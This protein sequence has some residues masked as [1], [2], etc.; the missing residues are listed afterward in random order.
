MNEKSSPGRRRTAVTAI[1]LLAVLTGLA[2]V[3]WYLWQGRWYET[4]NNAYLTGNL[5]E[6][7][8]QIGGTVVWIG[9]EQ[10]QPVRAGDEL[11]RLADGDE[12]QVLALRKQELAAAVQAVMMLR[13]QVERL[14]AE[15]RLQA[16]THEL[17]KE[18]FERRERL[19]ADNMVSEEE[20][21]TA[22]TRQQE[23]LLR[24][25]T[26]RLALA[27]A[28][29][30]AGSSELTEHPRI[31]AAAA[32]LGSSYR[33]WRK[34]RVIAPVSGEVARRRVQAGQRIQSG[35]PLFSIAQRQGAWVEANFKETQLRH[36]RPG[37]PVSI[38][39]DLYG[40]EVLFHGRVDSIGTG[41]GSVF[42]LL[43]PQNAT[44][45]WI[46]IVQRVP[47]RIELEEEYD[48]HH[49]LPFGAS[50]EVSVDTH[51]RSGPAI[52]TAAAT[53]P[54][55]SADLYGFQQE[56][57]DQL[58]AEVIDNARRQFDVGP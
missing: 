46:K 38:R 12:L 21:D 15:Q 8:A 44:G 28:K 54:V 19:Q 40:D 55:A 13:A 6:V 52:A 27:E 34:T 4:T 3:G 51:D 56:G 10:N 50:L 41:T 16:I 11:L 17:A 22:R 1:L 47:V 36:V 24:L 32:R 53:E 33:D 14:E 42:S 57:A 49:P 35:T 29:V 45:N 43:P 26:A 9:P 23:T 25:E 58:V 48:E 30:A 20:L 18:E 37:Q 5:V 7:S 2:A 31:M 39:S